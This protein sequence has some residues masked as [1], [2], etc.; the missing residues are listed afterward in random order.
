MRV[1]YS[2]F[3]FD[4]AKVTRAM[5]ALGHDRLVLITSEDNTFRD[6]FS[7]IERVCDIASTPMEVLV[8]DKF[9]LLQAFQKIADSIES[10]KKAREEVVV[11]VSGGTGLLSSA[12]MLAA[13]QTGV[14][15]YHVDDRVV[16]LPVLRLPGMGERLDPR[17]VDVLLRLREGMRL[18]PDGRYMDG[19]ERLD[20]GVLLELKNLG[21]LRTSVR[22]GIEISLT[23]L[24]R[25]YRDWLIKA[26]NA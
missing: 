13:F 4:K 23:D 6:D 12:A 15:A 10:R 11:N 7:E 20:V 19:K 26:R 21:L 2:T 17:Q 16:R 14:E 8:V 22:K 9:D 3:G 25:Y 18:G 1:L 24:G 5:R